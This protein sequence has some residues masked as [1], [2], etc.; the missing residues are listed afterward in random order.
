[1]EN[2]SQQELNDV[3]RSQC[4]YECR[5]RHGESNENRNT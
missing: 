2:R 3:R 4:C 1:M 5:D